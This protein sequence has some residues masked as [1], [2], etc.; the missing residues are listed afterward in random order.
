MSAMRDAEG[1]PLLRVEA[2]RVWF[3]VRAGL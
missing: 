3:P 2:L 1:E